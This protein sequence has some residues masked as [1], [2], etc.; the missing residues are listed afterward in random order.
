MRYHPGN[1]R[2]VDSIGESL[3]SLSV[4]VP[5]AEL[6]TS[7]RVIASRERQRRLEHRSLATIWNTWRENTQLFLDNV[8][9]SLALPFAGGVF[10]T[11]I[12]FSMVV[13]VD[14]TVDEQGRMLDYAVVAGAGVLANP[15]MRR[16]LENALVFS[17]FTPA[18]TFGQPTIS[19]MRLWFQ[20]SRI[21]VRG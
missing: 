13:V 1:L 7:L 17:N 20:S 2:G 8:V 18:T 4:K 9:L 15:Q 5:P 11:V 10:S 19:K 3:R 12:L 16:R 6:R 21:D 14:V